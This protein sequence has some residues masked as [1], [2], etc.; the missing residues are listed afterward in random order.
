MQFVAKAGVKH[1]FML[2]GGA[3]MHMVDSAGRNKHLEYVCCLHE[4]ACAFAAEAYAEYRGDLA[5]CLVTTGPGST[6]T[7]TGVAAAGIG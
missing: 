1:L 3:C 7:L 5:A 6:N 2:T 4:Q